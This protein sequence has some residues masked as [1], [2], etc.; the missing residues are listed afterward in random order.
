MHG[1]PKANL[2]RLLPPAQLYTQYAVH[3]DM[4]SL[5]QLEDSRRGIDQHQL[6]L[7]KL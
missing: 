6:K 4:T 2:W 3:H 7:S 5:M 1:L